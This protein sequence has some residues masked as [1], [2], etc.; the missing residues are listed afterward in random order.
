MVK[1]IPG[2]IACMWESFPTPNRHFVL[3]VASAVSWLIL[4]LPLSLSAQGA[5]SPVSASTYLAVPAVVDLGVVTDS[6]FGV[7]RVPIS[8]ISQS[9][10]RL[11][12]A[13][14]SC[15]CSIVSLPSESELDPG[16]ST[17]IEVAFRPSTARGKRST[18]V[19]IVAEA[20]TE[21]KGETI[22]LES[23]IV[24]DWRPLAQI[25]DG[26]AVF[27]TSTTRQGH[28]KTQ[29]KLDVSPDAGQFTPRAPEWVDIK[30]EQSSEV[31]R[32]W[33]LSLTIDPGHLKAGHY[34][35]YVSIL[36]DG[37]KIILQIPVSIEIIDTSATS[38][39]SVE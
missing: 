18:Q 17:E 31:S 38:A 10:I 2:A 23:E 8:N 3:I 33:Y 37:G 1:L 16:E 27:S 15:N 24:M 30:F 11:I 32:L 36:G 29:I 12:K 9:Q 28:S 13:I 26:K 22:H 34:S 4:A 35:D 25:L 19:A 14:A 5:E 6:R 21:P 39:V 20:K 7:A